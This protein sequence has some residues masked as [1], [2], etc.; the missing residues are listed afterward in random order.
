MPLKPSIGQMYTWVSHVHTHL[1]GECTHRCSYCYVGR[2]R[3]GR[4]EKYSGKMR[5]IEKELKVDY[6]TGNTIFIEHMNDLFANGVTHYMI[7]KIFRHIR[8]YRENMYVFQT[9]NPSRAWEFKEEFPSRYM[10]GTTIETN[11]NLP[12]ISLA[13]CPGSRASG[14][15]LWSGY[16]RQTFITIEPVMAFDP[17]VFA[18]MIISCKPSFVNIGADSKNTHLPEPSAD[19]LAELIERLNLANVPIRKKA[20]LERILKP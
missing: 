13:P 4:A 12:R 15:E 10:I 9:K 7:E 19:D 20:N 14:I 16:G 6:G 5:L 18:G 3:F 8:Q 2:N 17:A 11:R 1:G